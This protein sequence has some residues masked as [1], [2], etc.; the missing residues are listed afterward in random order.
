[1]LSSRFGLT[2]S[3]AASA[4]VMLSIKE[5]VLNTEELAFEADSLDIELDDLFKSLKYFI[6]SV[7]T[8]KVAYV[9]CRF[10]CTFTTLLDANFSRVGHT[11]CIHDHILRMRNYVIVILVLQ[12]L[13]KL[14][15]VQH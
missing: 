7:F 14:Q 13:D 8:L 12:G 5:A 1:M 6:M 11:L 4:K 15:Q 9:L 10:S 3:R 2:G